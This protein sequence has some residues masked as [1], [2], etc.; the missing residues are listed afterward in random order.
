MILLKEEGDKMKNSRNILG[1]LEKIILLL[2]ENGINDD[3]FAKAKENSQ[4]WVWS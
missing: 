4:D 1:H 3:F 2:L